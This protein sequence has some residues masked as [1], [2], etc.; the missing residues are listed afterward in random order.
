MHYKEIGLVN[1]KE[2]FNKAHTGGYAVPAFNFVCLEQLLAIADAGMETRTPIIIQSSSH[3]MHDIGNHMVMRMVQAAVERL[4]EKG[5][6]IPVALNLDHGLTFEDCVTCV[7]N[8]FSS[9][10][11]DGSA[12]PF[13]E[14]IAL[15]KKVVDYAHQYDVC[16]EGEL[17]TLSGIEEGVSQ[18]N[19]KYTDPDKVQEFVKKSGVDSLAISIGSSHGVVKIVPNPDGTLPELRFDILKRIEELIPGFPIVL[20]G[21]SHIPARFVAMINEHGGNLKNA[22]G[23]PE[24]QVKKAASMGV[25]KVNVASDGWITMTA[26]TRR[27]LDENKEMIDPRKFLKA[28]REEMKKVYIN[29]IV[30]VLGSE[31][32]GV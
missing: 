25:C 19:S 21:A 27:I 9:V 32:K 13:E 7:E 29:K 22:L 4:R 12:L 10:M 5:C 26:T 14:N 11:I 6:M 8:G 16:V 17:G 2:I 31:G 24:D 1:T 3:V 18:S 23:I 15:T 28:S 30:Q 20:H